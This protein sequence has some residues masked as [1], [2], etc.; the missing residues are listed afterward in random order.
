YVDEIDVMILCGGSATDL[1]DQAPAFARLFNTVDSYDTHALIPEYFEKVD[2]VSKENNHV[3]I[4]SVGW[5]P[6]LFSINLVMAEAVLHEVKMYTFWGKGL[7][8]GH[9]DA[10]RRVEG[11]KAGVQYTLPSQESMN[12]VRRSET[13][14]LTKESRNKRECYVVLDEGA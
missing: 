6:G 7:S 13:L 12:E 8:Q 3:N 5:D 9:S 10:V 2:K 11:V 14:T 4:I 1:P